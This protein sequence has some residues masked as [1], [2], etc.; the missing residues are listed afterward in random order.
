MDAFKRKKPNAGF[1]PDPTRRLVFDR[2]PKASIFITLLFLAF[3]LI[4]LS[5]E[6]IGPQTLVIGDRKPLEYTNLLR[7]KG[8][9]FNI[10]SLIGVGRTYATDY[11]VY[12]VPE[13]SFL[14]VTVGIT[15][16]FGQW[17]SEPTT[18]FPYLNQ[19]IPIT[20][21]GWK[22]APEKE[23][24]VMPLIY[25]DGY[26]PGPSNPTGLTLL[27]FN[28][29]GERGNYIT[30]GNEGCR[31]DHTVGQ[32]WTENEI[33]SWS[34]YLIRYYAP[35]YPENF[36]LESTPHDDNRYLEVPDEI[37][38]KIKFKTHYATDNASTDI[39][40]INGIIDYLRENYDCNI[41]H[42]PAP[43]DR[44]PVLWFMFNEGKGIS[45]HFNTALVMMTRTLGIP[46]RVV[47]GYEMT[48][49]KVNFLSCRE[50]VVHAEV[51]CEDI[52]WVRF[53]ATP[54]KEPRKP[55]RRTWIRLRSKDKEE[56]KDPIEDIPVKNLAIGAIIVTCL[57]VIA[58]GIHSLVNAKEKI[59]HEETPTLV[60][61]RLKVRFKEIDERYP[62]VW[63]KDNPLTVI[64]DSKIHGKL[65]L[66]IG[67]EAKTYEE[68]MGSAQHTQRYPIGEYRIS[69]RLVGEKTGSLI[70]S[71]I[72]L[73]I[74]EY[75]QEIVLLFNQI[76]KDPILAKQWWRLT[77]REIQIH[78]IKRYPGLPESVLEQFASL[79][80]F[81][82]YSQHAIGRE[83]YLRFYEAKQALEEWTSGEEE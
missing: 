79:F 42:R 45:I 57:F 26:I 69:A 7:I 12:G 18:Q 17:T 13:T 29:S 19:S 63:D 73:R 14:K 25:V 59:K 44:D 24:T 65:S 38:E 8:M 2:L 20:V 54:V 47:G 61:D 52:G 9:N 41:T 48:S 28:C 3:T 76:L 5:I 81:A 34:R 70:E 32:F 22:A 68:F 1:L 21:T 80:E 4:N 74:V 64:V 72:I 67:N 10:S 35:E 55:S 82:D 40:K 31:F 43:Y 51:W 37:A 11:V 23:I 27:E 75:K 30:K 49:S 46:S 78:L 60:D 15:Y 71:A 56:E 77:A 53:D 6:A 58:Y 50:R 33:E 62:N 83:E 16:D 66:R 39:E 36:T